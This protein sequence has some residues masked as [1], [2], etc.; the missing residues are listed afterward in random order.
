[1]SYA[2]IF[3][4]DLIDLRNVWKTSIWWSTAKEFLGRQWYWLR[5]WSSIPNW[6]WAPSHI[7]ERTISY[8]GTRFS[9]VIFS[10]IVKGSNIQEQYSIYLNIIQRT[11]CSGRSLGFI[12]L[13]TPLFISLL[14]GGVCECCPLFPNNG[15]VD[16]FGSRGRFRYDE[17]F[18]WIQRILQRWHSN[19][20]IVTSCI[21]L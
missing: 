21:V 11:I 12:T 19:W 20:V 15:Q 18:G 17:T 14:L 1:M 6:R 7:L 4:K 9:L 5:K 13:N 16:S 3:L 2:Q 8:E 10:L